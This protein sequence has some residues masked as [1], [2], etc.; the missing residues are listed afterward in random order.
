VAKLLWI[1]L[2]TTGTNPHLHSIVEIAAVM[3]IDGKEVSSFHSYVQPP[4]GRSVDPQ[5]LEICKLSV[6]D[7]DAFTPEKEV[8]KSFLTWLCEYVDRY[9]KRDKALIAGF[10]VGFDADFLEATLSRNG[11]MY[12]GSYF[13]RH[14]VDLRAFA[15]WHLRG[16]WPFMLNGKLMTVAEKILTPGE[17][18]DA[19][20]GG[21]AHG[22]PVD[23]RVTIEAFRKIAP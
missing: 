1:D 15:A 18:R 13:C 23:L 21:V 8:V 14:Y 19:M 3:E 2:E 16:E 9:D 17:L 11:E 12:F 20:G 5:A 6:S 10:N 22:A 7:L 4:P